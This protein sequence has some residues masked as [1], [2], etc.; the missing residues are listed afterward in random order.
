[1]NKTANKK[2]F[3]FWKIVSVPLLAG[4]LIHF[5][6]DITQDFLGIS[7]ILDKLGNIQEDISKFPEAL[8]QF[9]DWAIFNTY[10]FELILIFTI[11]QTW[12][13]KSFSKID[14]FNLVLILY[15]TIM[16]SIAWLLDPNH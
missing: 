12:K 4:I 8:R 10:L 14:I 7:T 1:M 5:F 16:F 13:R 9:Y 2:L 6:K 11:P 3:L 15:I